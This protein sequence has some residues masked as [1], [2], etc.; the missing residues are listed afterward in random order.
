[1]SAGANEKRS[2]WNSPGGIA[3]VVFLVAAAFYLWLEHRAH[4]LGL[5]PL[6]LPLLI[7]LGMHFF[8]HRGHG[9]GHDHGGDR[10]ER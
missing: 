8:M 4:L 1:M 6:L 10:D 7:C 5:L 3:L 2:F 9:G